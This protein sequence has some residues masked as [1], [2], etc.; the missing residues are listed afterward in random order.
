MVDSWQAKNSFRRTHLSGFILLSVGF[1]ILLAIAHML[2]PDSVEIKK[3]PS[4]IQIKYIAPEKPKANKSSRSIN[5]PT[6]LK[7]IEKARTKDLLAQFNSRAHSDTGKKT[8]KTY[9]QPPSIV[10]K[11]KGSMGKAKLNTVREKK[12]ARKPKIRPKIAPTKKPLP[13]SDIGK[14]R[15]LNRKKP[16]ATTPSSSSKVRTGSVLA[17]LDGFDP[18]PFASLNTNDLESIDDDEP[19]SLDTTEVKYASYFARIKHQIERVWIYP[20][21]AAKRGISGDLN[22]TFSISKDGNLLGA[23][24]LDRSGYEILDIAALKAVKEAAPF[25]PFPSN[26]QRKKLTIQ[27]NFIYTPNLEAIAP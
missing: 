15:T 17:L 21:D 14:N 11:T 12:M 10:P 23:R 3:G 26:F 16:S 6:P 2:S 5:T 7:K 27:A 1:H 13:E 19:V 18:E 20:N 22:L 25:Y 8:P 24:L 4:P 9:K